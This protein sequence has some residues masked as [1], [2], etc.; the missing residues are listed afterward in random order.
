M[1]VAFATRHAIPRSGRQPIGLA[2]H[3]H[4][5]GSD[6]TCLSRAA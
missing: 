1:L 3:Q 6:G 5:G 4:P 2:N